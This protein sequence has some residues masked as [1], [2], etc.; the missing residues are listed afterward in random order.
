[1][2]QINA[3]ILLSQSVPTSQDALVDIT[4]TSVCFSTIN[5]ALL[6]EHTEV[7]LTESNFKG[8]AHLRGAP[9]SHHVDAFFGVE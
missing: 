7:M 5:I 2:Q 3:I 6:Q 8:A 1:M 4:I 9:H